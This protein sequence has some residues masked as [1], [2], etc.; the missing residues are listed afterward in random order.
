MGPAIIGLIGVIIGAIVTSGFQWLGNARADSSRERIAARVLRDELWWWHAAAV[1]ALERQR[2]ADIADPSDLFAAWKQYRSDLAGLTAG[3]WNT[4]GQA[5][6]WAETFDDVGT[7]R[8]K[9]GPD[10]AENL[11]TAL[12]DVE[13]ATEVLVLAG[14]DN[15]RQ[16]KQMKRDFSNG[17]WADRREQ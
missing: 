16:R 11:K 17:H 8:A 13:A 2:L 1:G 9:W 14:A 4:I 12:G 3:D 15:T 10:R 7:R 6:R 5:V